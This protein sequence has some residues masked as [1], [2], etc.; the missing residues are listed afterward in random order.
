[1]S[2]SGKFLE[3]WIMNSPPII[4]YMDP[5]Y[6]DEFFADGSLRLSSFRVFR[7]HPDE[8]IGDTREGMVAADLNSPNSHGA[9][10]GM[11]KPGQYILC[12][13]LVEDQTMKASFNTHQALVIEN[14]FRFAQAVA[15]EIEGFSGGFEG[16]CVYRKDTLI[17]KSGQKNI[18]DPS[19]VGIEAWENDMRSRVASIG[20]ET[21]FLKSVRYAHQSEY[22]LVWFLPG[23]QADY[24]DIKVPDARAMC[25]RLQ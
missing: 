20:I 11:I 2:D 25:K 5:K 1:M 7:N 9:V 21:M 14:A 10:A 18:L 15:A 3:Q 22:R 23:E 17:S 4:R 19:V 16:P 12:G 6:V 8:Q 13:S 24:L